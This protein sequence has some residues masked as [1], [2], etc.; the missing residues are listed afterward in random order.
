MTFMIDLVSLWRDA[1]ADTPVCT[2]T[3][4]TKN[5][6][7]N[8]MMDGAH[9]Y[10]AMAKATPLCADNECAERNPSGRGC[11]ENVEALI[12]IYLPVYEMMTEGGGCRHSNCRV[13]CQQVSRRWG[14][15]SYPSSSWA[16]VRK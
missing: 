6:I 16:Q 12:S 9:S 14:G 15:R 3:G 8:A 1:K 4:T 7:L 13:K 10:E 2:V 11:R 5:M